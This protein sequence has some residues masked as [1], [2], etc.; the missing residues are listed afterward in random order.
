MR[1]VKCRH[2]E[3]FGGEQPAETPGTSPQPRRYLNHTQSD[4]TISF[5]NLS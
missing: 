2:V 1:G 5:E 3:K 4:Q